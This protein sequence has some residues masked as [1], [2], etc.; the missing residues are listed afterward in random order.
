MLW[1]YRGG[2]GCGFTLL[3][4]AYIQG[5][6]VKHA[7][8]SMKL[9]TYFQL[10]VHWKWKPEG[11]GLERGHGC[12]RVRTDCCTW[13]GDSHSVACR[14]SRS[15]PGRKD[16][17]CEDKPVPRAEIMLCEGL[18][19]EEQ[20]FFNI[21]AERRLVKSKANFVGFFL[22]QRWWGGGN[23]ILQDLLGFCFLS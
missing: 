17:D 3:S 14:M 8:I 18:G 21:P 22:S 9:S 12:W 2:H 19:Q 20:A 16:G 13:V 7:K 1:R 15:D 10:W 5:G 11:S 4:R 23:L 6:G